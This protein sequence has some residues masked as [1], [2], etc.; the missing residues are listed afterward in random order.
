MLPAATTSEEVSELFKEKDR[1]FE[2]RRKTDS[3][4]IF[5]KFL[6]IVTKPLCLWVV[7]DQTVS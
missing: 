1:F 4:D 3:P 2:S 6:S 5:A 7:L